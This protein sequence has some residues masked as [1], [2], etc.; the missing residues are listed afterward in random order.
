MVNDDAL[1]DAVDVAG[2]HYSPNDDSEKNFTRLAEEFDKEIWN[3]EAQATFSNTAF[4]PHNNTADPTV[5]G[6]GIGGNLS[7]LEMANTIVKGL[8]KS[9][10]THII[11]QPATGSFNER[12]QY[13]INELVDAREPSVGR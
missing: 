9:R 4:R 2:Y 12:G 8:V 6:T 3:S 10:C 11:Y 7:T 5:A 1:P 13:S